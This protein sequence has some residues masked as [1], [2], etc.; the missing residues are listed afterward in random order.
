MII[1]WNSAS[2]RT[3]HIERS[4]SPAA[5]FSSKIATNLPAS[6]PMNSYTDQPPTS[7]GPYFYRIKVQSP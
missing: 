4:T 6:P 2:N 5:G 7:A 1:R 3:Y